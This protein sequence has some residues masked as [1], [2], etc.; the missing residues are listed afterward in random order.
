MGLVVRVGSVSVALWVL[1]A[2]CSGDGTLV[3]GRDAGVD[4]EHGDAEHGDAGATDAGRDAG[5]DLDGA[6]PLDGRVPGDD[7]GLDADLD[8]GLD[9][10]LDAD[11]V[12][13]HDTGL[14]RDGMVI[15]L[16]GGP[17]IPDVGIDGGTDAFVP[18]DTRCGPEICNGLDDDCNGTV[19]DGCPSFLQWFD[20]RT[21]TS[22]LYGAATA[23]N[24]SAYHYLCPF[25]TVITGICGSDNG[26]VR[27]L[28]YSCGRVALVTDTTTTP[29]TYSVS[30][31]PTIT[32]TTGAGWAGGGAMPWTP[33]QCPTDTLAD[34]LL[35]TA[36]TTRVGQ[37]QIGCSGWRVVQNAGVWTLER[38]GVTAM[39]PRFGSGTGVD[40]DWR[41]A[42]SPTTGFPG[43]MRDWQGRLA[44]MG[45]YVSIMASGSQPTLVLH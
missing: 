14:D 13:G 19:D 38:S 20:P 2:G 11:L 24:S 44:D 22:P 33:Y 34:R 43:A 23:V 42:D 37:L 30:V 9:A 40:F 32:C 26:P 16:D 7:A 6:T 15:R 21:S 1:V 41:V 36:D 39:S 4:A 18:P 5:R 12:T 27:T 10:D 3:G 25:P 35:G 17:G 28:G 31:S 8:G 45:P 29:Y